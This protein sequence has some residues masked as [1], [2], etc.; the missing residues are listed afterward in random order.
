[1]PRRESTP[2][3]RGIGECKG[4]CRAGFARS[5]RKANPA[6]PGAGSHNVSFSGGARSINRC[7][8]LVSDEALG[9]LSL[10]VKVLVVAGV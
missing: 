7:G 5:S 6:M 4:S 2:G 1:M 9:F 3:F 8:S 10:V